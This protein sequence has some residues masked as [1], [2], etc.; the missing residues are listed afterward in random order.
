LKWTKKGIVVDPAKFNLDWMVTHAQNPFPEHIGGDKY[1]IHFA[2]REKEGRAQGG[3]V[4]IDVNDP[5]KI[6]EISQEP[7]LKLGKLGAFDD[8]GAMP[9]CIVDHDGSKYMYYTGWTQ[10]RYTPFSFF[11]GLV[12]SRDGGK[13]YERY[14]EAPVLGRVPESPYLA[15]S[16]WVILENGIWRMWY[17]SGD[18]WEVGPPIKH[19]YCIKYAESKNGVDWKTTKLPHIGYKDGNEYAIARPVVYKE[20][21]L[22]KMWYCYRGDRYRAGYAESADG[23]SW[24]R[25]DESAGIDTSPSGW[26]SEMICYPCVFKHGNKKVMLYN[27]NGFG[28]SGMG[29]AVEE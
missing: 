22:Y 23:I 9:S 15:A 2:G 27:G 3:Y 18:G 29:V 19:S 1:K 8:C 20:N 17:V 21:R 24:T 4:I 26:D 25:K 12:I 14:S 16:P 10:Q 7:Y 28:R 13:T 6:I 5:G 11:I